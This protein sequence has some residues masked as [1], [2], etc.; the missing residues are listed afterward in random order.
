[1]MGA[2]G[3]LRAGTAVA[4]VLM[5]TACAL[6][7]SPYSQDEFAAKAAAGRREIVAAVPPLTH[8][9]TLAEAIARADKFNL[10]SRVKLME[11]AQALDQLDV[12]KYDLLPKLTADAGYTGRSTPSAAVSR[13]LYTQGNALANPSYSTDRDDV[14]GDLTMTWNVLDFGVSYFAA[15]QQA[16]R[17]LIAGERRRKTLDTLV[18]D[19]RSAWW[20]AAA[21]QKLKG[22]VDSTL[23]LAERA[24][25][26]ARKAEQANIRNPIEILRYQRSMVESIRQLESI[27]EELATAKTEL[28]VLIG[29]PPGTPFEIAVPSDAELVPPQWT[30]PI[31]RMEELAVRDNPDL[32]EADYSERISVDDTRKA[33]LRMLPGISFSLSRQYD[34]NSFLVYNRWNEVGAR[35]A[36]NLLNVFSGP[37]EIQAAEAGETVAHDR[38]LAM[39]MAVLAQVHIARR[40]FEISVQQ[41]KRA[42]EIHAIDVRIARYSELR[43]QNDAQGQLDRVSNDT[44]LIVGLMRRY[45]TLAQVHA[46]LGRMEAAIGAAEVPTEVTDYKLDTLTRAVQARLDRSEGGTMAPVAAAPPAA[47]QVA[48]A[49]PSPEDAFA[50]HMLLHEGE[51]AT[52]DPLSTFLLVRGQAVQ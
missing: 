37:A 34:S 7:P 23:S 13:D 31:S 35:L 1:M 5:L 9:L 48:D 15:H 14:T 28:S 10:D 41:F 49:T 17:A 46:A 4:G 8:P 45:Q 29:L 44:T 50:V 6:S 25:A 24:L 22:S 12:S 42:S 26:D 36:W 27:E 11:Q 19:V 21:A 32:H 2:K 43:E 20:R 47:E 38:A 40:Q 30:M 39:Q 18:Q 51:M 16:D 3:M 33:I 52:S